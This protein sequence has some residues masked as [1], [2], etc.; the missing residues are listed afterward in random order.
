MN[1]I[2]TLLAFLLAL[3][4]LIVFHELGHYWVARLCNVKVLR[5]S[6]GMG[7]VIFSRRFGVDQTEW[8]I[9]ALPLGGYV[10]MLDVREQGS[11]SIP[12][13]DMAREFTS[14]SVWKRIA[15]VA[16]GP[17]A[18]FILA[19]A[20]FAVLYMVGVPEPV[21]KIRSPEPA[22]QAY[23]AGLRGN[24][25]ITAVNDRPVQLWSELHWEMLQC[26]VDRLPVRLTFVS[27]QPGHLVREV[28]LSLSALSPQ[29]LE[30]NFLGKLGLTL[31]LSP[32]RLG[33]VTPG[34]AAA[35]GGLQEGD[36]V[37][38]IDDQ[39]IVDSLDLIAIVRA[40]PAK[41]LQ[42]QVNR[43]GKMLALAVT[44]DAV[45][46]HEAT[47]GRLN[48]EVHSAPEMLQRQSTLL[49][50]LGQAVQRT[51]SSSALTLKM[52]GKMLLGEVSVKN[53]TGPLTIAEYAGQTAQSGLIS[54]LNFLAFI[55]IS[56]GVMNLL[57]IPVLD[58][59]HLLYYSLE[60]FTGRPLSAR[61]W[62]VAQR[63]G[64][65]VLLMLMVLAF[66]NDIVRLM[67]T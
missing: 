45:I 8:V 61:Y 66:Y 43:G 57:P 34:S 12:A 35:R 65:A 20:L 59:G 37:G 27:D 17:I 26:G 64:L 44:P 63:A 60:V 48:V 14:Q 21:S 38:A 18:N 28:Q 41:L 29:D 56:L 42:F 24:V 22:T 55:S 39:R 2:H 32:A 62:E 33:H 19:I 53:I 50:A 46:D 6:L 49:V 9:S 3:G 67:S 58:G 30:G 54:Y 40:S 5:F 31:A 7:K 52:I 51:W 23:M 11:D 13:A 10:K 47:V 36:V 4:L 1:F 15:I 25:L 16:A